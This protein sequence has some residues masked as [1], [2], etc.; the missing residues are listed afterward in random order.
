MTTDQ[1]LVS[2]ALSLEKRV[3]RLKTLEDVG[4]VSGSMTFITSQEL[5]V[6]SASI[7]FTNISQAYDDLFIIYRCRTARAFGQDY[8]VAQFNGDTTGGNYDTARQA[9]NSVNT[10]L[11]DIGYVVIG[12]VLGATAVNSDDFGVGLCLIPQ[13]TNTTQKLTTQ[14]IGGGRSSDRRIRIERSMCRVVESI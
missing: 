13:Y 10:C 14:S 11:K 12:I 3:E 6:A 2:Y 5:A 4:G 9:N 7:T 8:L 1:E